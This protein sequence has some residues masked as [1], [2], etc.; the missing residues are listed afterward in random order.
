MYFEWWRKLESRRTDC[1]W[2]SQMVVVMCISGG[3]QAD[4][5]ECGHTY[6]DNVGTG[7]EAV[8]SE[9]ESWLKPGRKG[10]RP[11][12]KLNGAESFDEDHGPAALGTSPKRSPCG[13]SF[14]RSISFGRN[15]T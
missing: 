12:S 13:S 3:S 7:A 1:R 6:G 9:I 10:R 15:P 4:G 14:F 5:G 8:M 2:G 11:P